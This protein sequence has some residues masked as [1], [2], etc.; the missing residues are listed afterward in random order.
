[1][2][3]NELKTIRKQVLKEVLSEVIKNGSSDREW[4]IK[5]LTTEISKITGVNIPVANETYTDLKKEYDLYIKDQKTLHNVN[6]PFGIVFTFEG[7]WQW[8]MNKYE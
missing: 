2:K 5:Y 3:K 8:L 7:F 4:V 6:P 1:M